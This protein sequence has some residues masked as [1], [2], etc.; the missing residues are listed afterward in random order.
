MRREQVFWGWG[1]PGA[2]P[3]LPPHADALLREQLGI[4]GGVVSR[5]VA[6]EDV[7]LPEPSLPAGL[8]EPDETPRRNLY[9]LLPGQRRVPEDR[10]VDRELNHHVER[11]APGDAAFRVHDDKGA[12]TTFQSVHLIG[13]AVQRYRLPRADELFR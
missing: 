6:L 8:R 12:T 1:E 13:S 10:R 4:D 5:P 7:R 2:G 3:S 9:A 11:Y